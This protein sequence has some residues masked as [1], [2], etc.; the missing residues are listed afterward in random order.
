MRIQSTPFPDPPVEEAYLP[1]RI[2]KPVTDISSTEIGATIHPVCA[3]FKTL[4]FAKYIF[5]ESFV[6]CFICIQTEYVIVS[7]VLNC[8]VLLPDVSPELF[9]VNNC[10]QLSC[11]FAGSIRRK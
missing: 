6:Q 2:P 4:L 3:K 5:R 10:P 9:L 1:I 11:D 8:Q 7:G